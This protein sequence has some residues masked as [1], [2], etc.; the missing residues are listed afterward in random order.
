MRPTSGPQCP[1]RTILPSLRIATIPSARSNTLPVPAWVTAIERSGRP[2][3]FDA[4]AQG[5]G[6]R[7]RRQD[8]PCLLQDASRLRTAG[9]EHLSSAGRVRP[10]I[11]EV[12]RFLLKPSEKTLTSILPPGCCAFPVSRN[13]SPGLFPI[14]S[15]PAHH[16]DRHI[17]S[18][19][20]PDIEARRIC[21][22]LKIAQHSDRPR[23][24]GRTRR[25]D[26]ARPYPTGPG[27][28]R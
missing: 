28:R 21:I 9:P 24:A 7:S 27:P 5:C 25:G 2:G 12:L 4:A 16:R 13:F 11:A 3:P 26:R 10:P 18:E 23:A 8:R 6:F 14:S 17:R 15:A 1:N 19:S 22:C 20:R